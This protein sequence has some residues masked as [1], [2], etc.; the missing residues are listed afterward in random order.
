MRNKGSRNAL[1]K[2]DYDVIGQLAG[3]AG[4]SAKQYAHRGEYDSR[5]L[6]SVLQWVNGRR[7][8]KGLPLIGL[9][10]ESATDAEDFADE[11]SYVTFTPAPPPQNLSGGYDPLLG[12]YRTNEIM[13]GTSFRR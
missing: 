3:S 4:D 13:G 5:S 11:D 1:L 6:D 9:P 7:A 10:S 12:G 2:I 8:A